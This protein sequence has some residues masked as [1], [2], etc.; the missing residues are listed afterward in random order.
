MSLIRSEEPAQ[1]TVSKGL[2]SVEEDDEASSKGSSI[3]PSTR[4]GPSYHLTVF[5]CR[6]LTESKHIGHRAH[7]LSDVL[8]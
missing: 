1:G 3:P 7:L 8:K 4:V 2:S 6:S 5:N